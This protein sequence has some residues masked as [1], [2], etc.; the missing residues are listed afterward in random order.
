MWLYLQLQ[1]APWVRF[2]MNPEEKMSK[3]LESRRERYADLRFESSVQ[4]TLP[5]QVKENLSTQIG[6]FKQT[7]LNTPYP[8]FE[9]EMARIV[10]IEEIRRF[11]APFN[12]AVYFSPFLDIKKNWVDGYIVTPSVSPEII[13]VVN[14]L[15]GVI[16]REYDHSPC[17]VWEVNL[18]ATK[19]EELLRA[20]KDLLKEWPV[21][22]HLSDDFLTQNL[23]VAPTINKFDLVRFHLVDGP[24]AGIFPEDVIGELMLLDKKFGLDFITPSQVQ[25]QRIPIANELL[26]LFSWYDNFCPDTSNSLAYDGLSHKEN[27]SR[28]RLSFGWD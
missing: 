23:E 3:W 12:L 5:L 13:N 26:D 9:M 16:Y 27:L 2:P 20:I 8:V 24:N 11:L 14:D 17:L 7:L 22:P 21:T 19:A 18:E 6:T 1:L 25:L 15:T 28:G 10:D 4:F